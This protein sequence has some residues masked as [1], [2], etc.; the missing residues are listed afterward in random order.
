MSRPVLYDLTSVSFAYGAQPVLRQISA[1]FHQGDFATLV[2][3]NGAGKSTV[4]KILAGL[5]R[6]FSG[7]ATFDGEDLRTLDGRSLSRRVAYVPQETHIAFPFTVGEVVLMGR[8]PH[9]NGRLLDSE[10]DR[11]WA[12]QA[13]RWTE[14][15]A[16]ESKNFSELSG[17]E[18]QRVVLAC[19]LAQAPEVLLLDEPTVYLDLKHQLHFFEILERLNQERSLTII[20]VT[21][22]INLSARY[23]SRLMALHQGN[24]VFDGAPDRVLTPENVLSVFG[25]NVEILERPDG[26]G[27]YI[28][29]TG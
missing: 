24:F 16:L 11:R 4:L 3:P 19:A 22:D 18:R 1:I 23:C 8:L 10:D 2:G 14:T 28:V 27:K 21:H 5:L 15:E 17:G 20:C 25:V 7:H 9:R 29:P 12:R 13:M 6:S 26:R